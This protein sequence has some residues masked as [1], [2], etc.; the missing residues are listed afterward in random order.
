MTAIQELCIYIASIVVTR[1]GFLRS[2]TFKGFG[3]NGGDDGAR[4]RGLCRDSVAWLGFTIT[5]ETAG[6]AKL[7]GSRT[8]HRSLW[9]G[10]WVGKISRTP[11]QLSHSTQ[12]N[13]PLG[14]VAITSMEGFREIRK[15]TKSLCLR[16]T[17]SGHSLSHI[18]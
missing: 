14:I 13:G 18:K 16:S 7:R 5:Y 1:E 3:R 6:T 8:R 15:I 12:I 10:L 17:G 11:K 9:V 2:L 4:T